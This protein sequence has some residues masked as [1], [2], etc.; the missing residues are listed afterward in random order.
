MDPNTV[1]KINFIV[2]YLLFSPPQIPIKKYIGINKASK[3]MNKE[4]KSPA[5][6]TPFTDACNSN[7]DP[8]KP[9]LSPCVWFTERTDNRT[10]KQ[11]KVTSK[12]D[13]PEKPMNKLIPYALIQEIESTTIKLDFKSWFINI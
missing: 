11:F 3:K 5:K 12:K 4:T 10:S 8:K 9:L 2:A 1:Y 6:N 7:I 13:I